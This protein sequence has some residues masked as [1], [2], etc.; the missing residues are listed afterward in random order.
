MRVAFKIDNVCSPKR[1]LA[2]WENRFTEKSLERFHQRGQK[3]KCGRDTDYKI[4]III[5]PLHE[6]N[7]VSHHL[8]P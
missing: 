3:Y 2:F 1:Y 4:F 5:H 8:F 6:F 7:I